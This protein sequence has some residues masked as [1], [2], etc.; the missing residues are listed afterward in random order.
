MNLNNNPSIEE[1]RILFSE[2]DDFSG[3]H[4]LWVDN[5]SEVSIS[6]SR[7]PILNRL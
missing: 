2:A 4:V 7:T 3:H 1:L 5:A 6:Y